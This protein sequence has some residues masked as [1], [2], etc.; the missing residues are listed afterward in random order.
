MR[1]WT[2]SVGYFKTTRPLGR[3]GLTSIPC[4]RPSLPPHGFALVVRMGRPIS[5]VKVP[6]WL[7]ERTD[8]PAVAKIL[9]AI[10]A[11]RQGKN[12]VC[13]PSLRRLAADSGMA[14]STVQLQLAKL[15]SRGLLEPIHRQSPGGRSSNRYRVI[16]AP[17]L[18]AQERQICAPKM[19]AQ[20]DPPPGGE[21]DLR[22]DSED[23]A[24]RGS[25]TN[26][27]REPLGDLTLAPT[28]QVR[29]SEPMEN[30]AR[31]R[32]LRKQHLEGA[33]ADA[34]GTGPDARITLV[35]SQVAMGSLPESVAVDCAREAKGKRDPVAWFYAAIH[36]RTE[37]TKP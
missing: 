18:G 31:E 12:G 35:A 8:L 32:A 11:D 5:Y 16:C 29:T 30:T 4:R 2:F 28:R 7:L 36:K 3:R 6:T 10:L 21:E 14:V 17:N 25:V 33:L 19:S 37:K 1:A 20:T 22:T 13:W 24:H 26:L 9:W 27:L 34:I 23:F 15:E